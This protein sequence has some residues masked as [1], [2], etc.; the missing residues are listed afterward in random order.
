MSRSD[1][2]TAPPN[3]EILTLINEFK[4]YEPESETYDEYRK[5]ICTRTGLNV[6]R[7]KRINKHY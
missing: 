2:R 7:I 4:L 1:T 6:G 3:Q 5:L